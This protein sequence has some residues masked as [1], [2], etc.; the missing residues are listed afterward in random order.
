MPLILLMRNTLGIKSLLTDISLTIEDCRE[1]CEI[2][3]I[4]LK[5]ENDLQQIRHSA[6]LVRDLLIQLH[7]VIKPGINE[8]D[9]ASFC[10]NYILLRG[11]EPVLKTGKLFPSAVSISTNNIAF[12]GVPQNSIL[13]DGDIVTVDVV[14]N[15]DGW[16]GD[17][18]WT[19][20]VGDCSDKIKSLVQFASDIIYE[21]VESLRESEDLASIG[22]IVTSRCDELNF[23]V[24]SEGAGHGIGR[25]LHEDPQIL[26]TG[27]YE[28]MKILPGMVF[29]IEPVITD[30]NSELKYNNDRSAYLPKGS[31]A[32]QFEH[33]VAI[34]N[35]GI[36]IL[37]CRKS[38]F[39]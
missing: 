23:R 17:G 26:Y 21:A 28:T 8:L 27:S 36:E 13:K 1:N 11:A 39:K 22:N 5:S 16:Y 12:H 24:L 7:K 20:V 25:S 4:F 32:A 19:Y 9:I 37:T 35:S 10:E 3:L 33:M 15:K 31:H 18:A 38:L 34:N 14:L 2:E 30:S 6:Y 29:T